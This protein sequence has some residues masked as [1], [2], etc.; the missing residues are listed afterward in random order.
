MLFKELSFNQILFLLVVYSVGLYL[1]LKFEDLFIVPYNPIEIYGYFYSL[2][3]YFFRTLSLILILPISL[4]SIFGTLL[5]R[6]VYR[7][8]KTVNHAH[9]FLD[10]KLCIRVVTRGMF[11]ELIKSNLE[12]H[13]NLLKSFEKLQYTYEIITDVTLGLDKN[14][15][16]Y[17][18]VVPKEYETKSGAKFKG[19]ALQYAIELNASNLGDDDWVL[20][21]DEES[22]L[23]KSSI[24]GVIE[25]MAKNKHPIGQGKIY[26]AY[27]SI[28][29]MLIV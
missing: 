8:Q 12:K 10:T 14:K 13:Q 5:C 9:I 6:K 2:T 29:F 26:T 21:L 20:H 23:T 17:E 3:N 24:E 28:L 1:K 19:R 16:C 11:P 7:P 25:F 22:L 27:L 18:V 4:Y 15:E